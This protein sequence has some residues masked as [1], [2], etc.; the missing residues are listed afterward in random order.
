[1][2][3]IFGKHGIQ[4]YQI[5]HSHVHSATFGLHTSERYASSNFSTTF[6]STS[7]SLLTSTLTYSSTFTSTSLSFSVCVHSGTHGP[8]HNFY[9]TT[10][11]D[12]FSL[13]QSTGVTGIQV[14]S[15]GP[16]KWCYNSGYA[17]MCQPSS[18]TRSGKINPNQETHITLL[19]LDEL[20][21]KAKDYA[22]MHGTWEP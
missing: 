16:K 14:R 13:Y 22:L 1:M 5:W 12:R 2:C 4:G 20:V 11:R 15:D 9:V 17:T 7:I 18:S 6:L 3:Y 10:D 8:H 19:Q 21:E